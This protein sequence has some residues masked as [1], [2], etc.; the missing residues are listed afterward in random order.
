M[1]RCTAE[2]G[3]DQFK[4]EDG[5]GGV[6]WLTDEEAEQFVQ[7]VNSHLNAVAKKVELSD[8]EY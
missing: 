3:S 5:I 4:I 7:F 1:A 2:R 8:K 6:A